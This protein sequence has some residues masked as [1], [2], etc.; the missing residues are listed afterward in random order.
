MSLIT[1]SSDCVYQ[2]DGYCELETLS[3]INGH[4]MHHCMHYIARGVKNRRGKLKNIL[5]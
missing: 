3:T 4:Q 2:K 5:K 1:C